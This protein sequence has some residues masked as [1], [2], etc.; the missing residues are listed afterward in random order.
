MIGI[1][2]EESVE[3][4][5]NCPTNYKVDGECFLDGKCNIANVIYRAN[6]ECCGDYYIGKTQ[7]YVKKRIQ[8][9]YGDVVKLWKKKKEF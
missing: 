6:C 2:D 9:H 1:V 5:C 7:K 4:E 8:K 3:V